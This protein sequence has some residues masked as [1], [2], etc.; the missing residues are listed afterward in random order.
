MGV[1]PAFR[2]DLMN[3]LLHHLGLIPS[4]CRLQGN[5]LPVPVR[6]AYLII[7]NNIQRAHAASGKRFHH[8]AAH[9]ADTEHGHSGV[10]KLLHRL[11]SEE[12]FCS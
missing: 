7:I 11:T 12:A 2:V 4:Y 1:N 6:Q 5:N 3:A 9:T 8:I 10:L